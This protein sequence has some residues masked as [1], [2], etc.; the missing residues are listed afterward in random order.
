MSL[1]N[2]LIY[3]FADHIQF[4]FCIDFDYIFMVFIFISFLNSNII[5][6]TISIVSKFEYYI[7]WTKV[8]R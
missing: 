4:V 5:L 8:M 6:S 3:E 2:H 7:T 1:G